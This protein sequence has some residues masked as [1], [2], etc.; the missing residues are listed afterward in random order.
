MYGKRLSHNLTNPN[1]MEETHSWNS[2]F[3]M[4]EEEYGRKIKLSK[5]VAGPIPPQFT[6]SPMSLPMGA[7][8]VYRD[9]QATDSFQI[10]EYDDHYT[11]QMDRHNPDDGNAL[12]HAV[13]DAA[14]YTAVATIGAV[15]I[16]GGGS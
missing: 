8:Q 6:D 14:A 1:T 10:R 7:N 3:R 15:A 12:A 9:Q 16:F 2:A 13:T 4:A 5:A 11:V